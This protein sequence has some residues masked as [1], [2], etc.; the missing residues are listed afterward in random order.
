MSDLAKLERRIKELEN[1]RGSSFRFAE[2]T[3]VDEKTG[4]ARVKLPDG[5]NLVSMPLRV[6]QR[7]TLKDQSQELPDVGEHVAC[8]FTGQGFEQGVVLGAVYS[9]PD[10]SPGRPSHCWYMKFEDGTEVEYDRKSHSLT[11]TVK[12]SIRI[13]TDDPISIEA[14]LI[15][16]KADIQMD[17]NLNVTGNINA[18]GSI[19]DGAGNTN[20]HSHP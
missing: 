10:A 17:G 13:K 8:L 5:E 7:R 14:P 12:G 6:S 15:N 2:V 4:T 1:N 9:R 16:I 3:S 18:S 20:H 19:I 11:M